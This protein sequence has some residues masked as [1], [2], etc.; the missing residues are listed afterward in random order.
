[1]SKDFRVETATSAQYSS[2][3]EDENMYQDNPDSGN[4]SL[5]VPLLIFYDLVWKIDCFCSHLVAKDLGNEN[6]R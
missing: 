3:M 6:R 4:S 1:M 2:R 5:I